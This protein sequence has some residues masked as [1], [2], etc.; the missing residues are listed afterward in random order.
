M[1]AITLLNDHLISLIIMLV[2]FVYVCEIYGNKNDINYVATSKY[3]I[4]NWDWDPCFISTI[5]L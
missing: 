3:L 2:I 1:R 5:E 4:E